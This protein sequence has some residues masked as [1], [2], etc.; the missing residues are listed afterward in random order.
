MATQRGLGRQRSPTSGRG[1]GGREG[2]GVPNPGRREEPEKR[3][4]R[5]LPP[6]PRAVPAGLGRALL[7]G[8]GRA[9]PA[10]GSEGPLRGRLPFV[11]GLWAPLSSPA[12]PYRAAAGRLTVILQW[13]VSGGGGE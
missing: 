12:R 10:R 4:D 5:L 7:R 6:E 8:K 9:R 3:A 11:Q 2:P 13:S 1:D